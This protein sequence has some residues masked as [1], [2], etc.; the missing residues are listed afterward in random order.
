M[1]KCLIFVFLM[2]ILFH[3]IGFT[4]SVEPAEDVRTVTAKA[5]VLEV[6][7]EEKIEQGPGMAFERQ[8]FRAEITSSEYKGKI[9]EVENMTTGNIAYDIKVKPGDKV[10]LELEISDNKLINAYL[11]D[12]QRENYIYL[13][14]ALFIV[15]L[16]VIGRIK[17]I[18]TIFTLIVTVL[19]IGK[20][21]LPLILRGYNPILVAIIIAT[22]VT[23]ITLITISGLTKKTAA[24]VIGTVGGVMTAAVISFAVGKAAHLTGMSADEAQMLMFIPQNIKFNFRDLLFAGIIVGALGAVMDV[25]MSIASAMDEIKK[26]NP[27]VS[28][29]NLIKSGMNMGKD[30]MGTMANT[31]ILAYTGT[32][33]PLLLLFMAYNQSYTKI[34]NL[35]LIATEFVRAL[36]GS[37]G[38][39]FSIPLTALAAGMLI[40]LKKD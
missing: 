13:L 4:D 19:L 37:I 36:S 15:L 24:A 25:A 20:M 22:V 28:T 29:G 8:L 31:L 6:V 33:I 21:L 11:A 23:A 26:A 35:D 27:S 2:I 14:V 40:G 18:K 5:K 3:S 39:I 30:I 10:I 17:G 16:I 1:K 9:L 38:L 32:S 34:I 7:K 12:Y